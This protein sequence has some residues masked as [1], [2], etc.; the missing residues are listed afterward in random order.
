M[1]GASYQLALIVKK[2]NADQFQF[3]VTR[4]KRPVPEKFEGLPRVDRELWDLPLAP[5]SKASG[6]NG[7]TMSPLSEDD[8]GSLNVTR[9]VTN[10][11]HKLGLSGFNVI[12]AVTNVETQVYPPGVRMKSW[13]Y[14]RLVEET[15][16]GPG[17]PLHTLIFITESDFEETKVPGGGCW[18]NSEATIDLLAQSGVREMR[19]GPL[20][21]VAVSPHVPDGFVNGFT[22][23]HGQDYPPGVV[24]VPMNSATIKPFSKTNLV[25]FSPSRFLTKEIIMSSKHAASGDVLIADPGCTGAAQSELKQIVKSLPRKMLVFLTHHHCDHTDGLPTVRKQNP[26][27]VLVA[28]EATFRRMGKATK[29]FKCITIEGGSKLLVG[30]RELDVIS[31]PGHTDGHLGFY[32]SATGTLVVGDHCVGQGSSFLDHASG[33]NLQD[34]FETTRRLLDLGPHM[35]VPMHGRPNLWPAHMLN[36]YIKHREGRELKILKVIEAGARSAFEIVSS[37]Y[38]DTPA[39][40]WP[41]ALANVKLHVEH[42]KLNGKLPADFS[43]AD[44]EKSSKAPFAIKC[45]NAVTKSMLHRPWQRLMLASTSK[46]TIIASLSVAVVLGAVILNWTVRS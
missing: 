1:A 46:T 25:I 22:N 37:A 3:L 12:E 32:D 13:R 40:L 29:G 44:F 10:S 21:A 8:D 18:L 38:A 33:G 15:N 42:L 24:I 36:G 23:S 2:P 43:V 39:N 19:I 30:G 20:A 4:Q 7:I 27:A 28:H 17:P 41:W 31:A 11:I 16:Y 45:V 26:E 35:I 6:S 9:C 5:L 34:Y 14:W